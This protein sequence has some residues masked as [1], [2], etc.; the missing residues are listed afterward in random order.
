MTYQ[1]FHQRKTS[2]R[3]CLE[4]A[5]GP[6]AEAYAIKAIEEGRPA[7]YGLAIEPAHIEIVGEG[8]L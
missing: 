7:G 4:E 2:I 1:F 6:L 5:V 8:Y 3:E